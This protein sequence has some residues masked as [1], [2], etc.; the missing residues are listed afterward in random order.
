MIT[1]KTPQSARLRA[2]ASLGGISHSHYRLLL[3][4]A[5]VILIAIRAPGL[6]I[7]PRVWAEEILYLN[8]ALNHGILDSL[9]YSKPS[10]GYYLLTANVPAVLQSLTAKAFGLEYAPAVTTYFAFLIQLIPFL[11]LVYEKSHFFRNRLLVVA[12]CMLMLLAPTAS[13]ETWLNSIHTKS[14]TGLAAFIILF[15]DMSQ[16][17]RKRAWFYRF[18]VLFCGVSGPYAAILFP[19]FAISYFVYRERE[20]FVQAAILAGCCVLHLTLFIVEIQSGQ[21]G[22]RTHAFTLDSAIVNVF[23]YQ[24]AWSF[25]G[26]HA[27]VFCDHQL[28]LADAIQKSSMVPRG[29]RVLLAAWFCGVIMCLMLKTFWDRRLRSQN[30]L[31]ILS[32]LLYAAFTAATALNGIPHNRYTLLP[33]LALLL[34]LLSAWVNP[35]TMKRFLAGA[36]IMLALYSGIR[37]YRKFWIEWSAGEPA[38]SAEVQRW[39]KDQSYDPAIWPAWFPRLVW[40]PSSRK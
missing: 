26:Y 29:G 17:S 31:L 7:H 40:H 33:G 37:D 34:V 3:I 22:V 25:L 2:F 11:I 8:Y 19:I 30:T 27:P 6:L 36:L 32:F 4:L 21:A 23:V 15:V 14:W 16:W 20:R 13:G 38:W 10:I 18:V 28:G 35:G 5:V 9:L 24:V 39:R 1:E 12:G